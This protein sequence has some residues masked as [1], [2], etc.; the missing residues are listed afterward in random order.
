MTLLPSTDRMAFATT[1][2]NDG[3]W[4]HIAAVYDTSDIL[5]EVKIYVDGV[6]E[7]T[8]AYAG[9]S[10]PSYGYYFLIGA[11]YNYTERYKG[12]MDEVRI[13]DTALSA[14]QIAE[15]SVNTVAR[16][17]IVSAGRRPG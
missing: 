17:G 11:G 14:A 16:L 2:V 12:L 5:K 8:D 6:L 1:P 10:I 13:S 9:G 15:D 7:G 3:Q 4:H